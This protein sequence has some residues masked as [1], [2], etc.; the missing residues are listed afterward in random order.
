MNPNDW[1][2]SALA[3]TDQ[4]TLVRFQERALIVET[5]RLTLPQLLATAA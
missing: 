4:C 5:A 3:R 2:I 1:S